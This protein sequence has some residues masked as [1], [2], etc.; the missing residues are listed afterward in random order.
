YQNK[1]SLLSD[2]LLEVVGNN[3]GAYL[4]HNEASVGSL[5]KDA[6]PKRTVTHQNHDSGEKLT[7][8]KDPLPFSLLRSLCQ[9]MMEH[10]SDDH[11]SW[12]QDSLDI[13]F[14]HAKNDQDGTRSRD[15]RHIYA[16]PFLPEICP[17]LSLAIYAA[18]FGLGNSK[19]FP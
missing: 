5:K 9:S 8:G 17:I 2:E 10:G 7:E 13:R 14:G 4:E 16:N 18:V 1:R 15:A 11:I 6:G 12:E 3:E 19:L